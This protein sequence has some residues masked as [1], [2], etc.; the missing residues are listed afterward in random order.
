M[1]MPLF[2]LC[3]IYSIFFLG[4]RSAA[5]YMAGSLKNGGTRES[6][7]P[8]DCTC[9]CTCAGVWAHILGDPQ[10][11]QLRNAITLTPYFEEKNPPKPDKA[12]KR[13]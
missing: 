3:R 2:V 9:T 8:M 7:H 13:F 10:S 6:S 4:R 11:V 1:S 12:Y 5:A